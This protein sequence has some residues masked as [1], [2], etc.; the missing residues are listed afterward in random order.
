MFHEVRVSMLQH[1]THEPSDT[2]CA[3]LIL[4]HVILFCNSL[5]IYKFHKMSTEGMQGI[6][7]EAE[8]QQERLIHVELVCLAEMTCL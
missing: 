5:T 1:L 6:N 2:Q 3:V 7:M 4:H 8:E